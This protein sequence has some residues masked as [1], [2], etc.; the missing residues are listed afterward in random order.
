MLQLELLVSTLRVNDPQAADFL[1]NYE[2]L[3]CY[4][5]GPLLPL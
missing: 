5:F 2:R 4:M 3:P 1:G